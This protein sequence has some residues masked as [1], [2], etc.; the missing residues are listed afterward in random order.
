MA[1]SLQIA[2][3]PTPNPTNTLTNAFAT[4][5]G[6]VSVDSDAI[7]VTITTEAA[8]KWTDGLTGWFITSVTER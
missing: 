4:A 3:Q 8:H 6:V 7:A 2:V 5:G 1:G